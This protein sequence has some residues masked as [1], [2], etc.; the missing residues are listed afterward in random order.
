MTA[1]PQGLI[2]VPAE[3]QLR[4]PMALSHNGHLEV[5]CPRH[6]FRTGRAARNEVRRPLP[7]PALPW[8]PPKGHPPRRDQSRSSSAAAQ[9]VGPQGLQRR[10]AVGGVQWGSR[11][12]FLRATDCLYSVGSSLAQW[13]PARRPHLFARCPPMSRVWPRSSMPQLPRA[14]PGSETRFLG[15]RLIW[16]QRDA[17]EPRVLHAIGHYSVSQTTH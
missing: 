8:G 14:Q 6:G 17:S 9:S 4:V 13:P 12:S 1:S 2:E 3:P 11:P 15:F 7:G 16:L 10:A 5:L